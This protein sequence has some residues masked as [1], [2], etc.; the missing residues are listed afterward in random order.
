MDLQQ[1]AETA[2]DL[3]REGAALATRLQGRVDAR[4]KGGGRGP[5]TEAD[6]AVEKLLL[7]GLRAAFPET[8]I[9]AEETR[10]GV[11]R[12]APYLWCVDPIDGTREYVA[13]LQEYAVQIGL[14]ADGRPVAGA[15]VLPATGHVLWGWRDGGCHLEEAG[16]VRALRP[17]PCRD[18][19][20]ATAIHTRSHQGPGLEQALERLGVARRIEAGG[21][22]FK[23]A[24]VLLGRAHLYLHTGGGTTWWDSVGP[25]A[26]ILAAGG[27]VA[28]ATGSPLRYDGR[29]VRHRRGLLFAA[30]GLCE[31]V[32]ARLADEKRAPGCGDRGPDGPS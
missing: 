5:V 15:V 4:D 24:Q 11:E 31:V 27:A 25:G 12:P 16:A 9:L 18:L 14:L 29:D 13:G 22:G 2:C 21:V 7:K 32:A 17:A 23:A 26:L 8:P 20:R 3:A 1:A 6:V 10:Q 30:P 19:E 28:D